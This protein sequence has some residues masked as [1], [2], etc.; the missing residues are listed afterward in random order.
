[1]KHS[2]SESNVWSRLASSSHDSSADKGWALYTETS[3]IERDITVHVHVA[4]G[5]C[6]LSVSHV[7]WVPG[8]SPV[9]TRPVA[10]PLESCVSMPHR[11]ISSAHHKVHSEWLLCVSTDSL[12]FVFMI[13]LQIVLWKCGIWR[14]VLTYWLWTSISAMWDVSVTAP[15]IVSS[16]LQVS[17]SSR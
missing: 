5:Q 9:L 4:R 2:G 3:C 15:G 17:L 7:V 16:S 8:S 6:S 1:M 14:L 13:I 10:T 11:T 12:S